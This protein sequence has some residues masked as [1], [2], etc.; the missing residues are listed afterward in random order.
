MEAH[1][2]SDSDLAPFVAKLIARTRVVA[3]VAKKDKFIFADLA[4]PADLRLDYDVT[5]LPPKKAF[6]PPH[7]TLVRFSGKQ[8]ESAIA[9]VDQILFG[10]HPYDIKAIDQLDQLFEAGHRDNNYLANREHT[11][12]VG[13]S[14]QQ[15]SPRAFWASIGCEREPSGHDAFLT[16]VDGGY[17][18]E[19]R[20]P[21]G[22]A[23]LADG[24]FTPATPAQVS[25]AVRV[26]R[27]AAERCAVQIKHGTTEISTKV[28]ASF[29]NE[30]LWESLAHDCFSCGTCNVVCP[31]CYCFDVQ[32][33]WNLDQVSGERARSWDGC[34]LENFAEVSLGGGQTENFR[35]HPADRF[36]HRVMRKLTYLNSKLGAPACVGCGRCS[37]QCVP[38]IADPVHIVEKIMEA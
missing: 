15:V 22:T 28:R 30:A 35:E 8:I 3:P 16:K 34:L 37:A 23:L 1:F 21:R 29:G 11:T 12:I 38:D 32:D 10:V 19:V 13:S 17:V 31:T 18:F 36:R 27:E 2:L 7:Q 20:T 24:A 26:N 25:D 4:S 14:V 9:P 33:T 5:I 6:F